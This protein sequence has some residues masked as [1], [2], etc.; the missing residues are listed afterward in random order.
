M[1]KIL[2]LFLL[3][4]LS[5]WIFMLPEFRNCFVQILHWNLMF[6]WTESECILRLGLALNCWSQISH[7]YRPELASIFATIIVSKIFTLLDNLICVNQ[8]PNLILKVTSSMLKIKTNSRKI[9]MY[10]RAL[11]NAALNSADLDIVLITKKSWKFLHSAEPWYYS[12]DKKLIQ[13]WNHG[14]SL[15]K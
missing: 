11:H 10:T 9:S 2:G 8:L 14:L 5:M 3:W 13:L 15:I 1:W 7:L 4:V 12:A 6:W